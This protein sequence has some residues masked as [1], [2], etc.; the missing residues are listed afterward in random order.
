MDVLSDVPTPPRGW[1][2]NKS[3]QRFWL[4]TLPFLYFGIPTD[5]PPRSEFYHMR[6]PVHGRVRGSHNFQLRVQFWCLWYSLQIINNVWLMKSIVNNFFIHHGI[7]WDNKTCL[8]PD[9]Q[10]VL[11]QY[12]I[13][14]TM[15]MQYNLKVT[16]TMPIWIRYGI[17]YVYCYGNLFFHYRVYG[18]NTNKI[19]HH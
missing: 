14:G 10:R 19:H 17:V 11:H 3:K 16:R 5:N 8:N 13:L 1:L 4:K 18:N 12:K 9:G 6:V 2:W 15:Q 7:Q